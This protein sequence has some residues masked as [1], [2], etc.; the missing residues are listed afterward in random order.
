MHA[1]GAC[2]LASSA[3]LT[4]GCAWRCSGDVLIAGGSG[5]RWG[6]RRYRS[7]ALVEEKLLDLDASAA[8]MTFS[9]GHAAHWQGRE[10]AASRAL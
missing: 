2:H 7:T 1:F 4:R 8:E 5:R 6:Q 3:K 10:G 9:A